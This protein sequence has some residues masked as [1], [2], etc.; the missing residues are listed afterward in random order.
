M[1][2]SGAQSLAWAGVDV[3][4]I[5]LIGRWK[6]SAVLA[7]VREAPLA[8]TTPLSAQ[9]ASVSQMD[10]TGPGCTRSHEKTHSELEIIGCKWSMLQADIRE[11]ALEAAQLE[12]PLVGR[13]NHESI[14]IEQV[15]ISRPTRHLTAESGP[16]LLLYFMHSRVLSNCAWTTQG[17]EERR[18]TK[19]SWAV[20]GVWN[21]KVDQASG[22]PPSVARLRHERGV[23][24]GLLASCR[25]RWSRRFLNFLQRWVKHMQNH[26]AHS[27][28]HS[29]NF[30]LNAAQQR[31]N[32]RG[33]AQERACGLGCVGGGCLSAKGASEPGGASNARRDTLQVRLFVWQNSR[34]RK[35]TALTPSSWVCPVPEQGSTSAVHG[36]QGLKNSGGFVSPSPSTSVRFRERGKVALDLSLGNTR[37][38]DTAK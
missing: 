37:G 38:P 28:S 25:G 13:R 24:F 11:E 14:E 9:L 31:S 21:P 17:Q 23:W 10:S 30:C 34:R 27:H 20:L 2:V 26:F 32:K 19:F 36:S 6:S 15:P 16:V 18:S 33:G 3:W 4:P 12:T 1:R 29:L 22:S 5:Q 8:R 35:E 7:Y